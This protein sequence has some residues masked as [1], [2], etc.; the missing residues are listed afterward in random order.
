MATCDMKNNKQLPDLNLSN[1]DY[2]R[3]LEFAQLP[4]VCDLN[5]QVYEGLIHPIEYVRAIVRLAIK[6]DV[7]GEYVVGGL[8]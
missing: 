6:H 5:R 3:A 8:P 1:P 7:K 4:E 2:V